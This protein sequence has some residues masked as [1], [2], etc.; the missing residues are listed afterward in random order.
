MLTMAGRATPALGLAAH[1]GR[2]AQRLA[3]DATIGRM[4][5][6]PRQI[7]DLD[8]AYLSRLTGRTVRSVSVIGGDAGTSSRARLA[9]SGDPDGDDAPASVFVK[10]PAQTAATRM[11]GE[12]GR[13]GHTEVRFYQQLAAGLPGVPRAYGAA[14][15]PLTGRFVLVLEDLT[16]G[17]CEFPDTLHPLDKDRAALTVELLARVHAAFW[18]RLP[19]RSGTGPLGWLYSASGDHTS[20]LTGSLLKRST[21]RLAESTDIPVAE[22]RF[23]D[24]NYR[25]AAQ[26]LDRPPHTVMHGDAHPGN[27]FFRNGAAGL[28]D[29]QAVRRGHP[30]RELAYTLITSMTTA[31]RRAAER[32]LLDE[33]RCALAAAGGP[34]LA[35]DELWERYRLGA[36]YAYTAPV[37]TAGLG[38]MQ[39]EGIALEGARRGVAALTD[40][41]TVAILKKLL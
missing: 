34:Q 24:E 18:G 4:R 33:Y 25:A 37:I 35:H 36:L 3:T 10:M 22:G 6:M 15:D 30:G 38:G 11:L 32:D 21:K 26:L 7:A 39:A 28:L 41:E 31:D 8:A 14:F 12:L 29:W 23:I 16:L 13:L 17:P 40:L 2:G 19:Q 20:L 27:L 1:L 9:L 5:A